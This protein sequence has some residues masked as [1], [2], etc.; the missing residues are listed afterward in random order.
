[1]ARVGWGPG[2]GARAVSADL[3]KPAGPPRQGGRIR[4]AGISSSTADTLD[5]ARGSLSTDYVRHN[6]LYSGLTQFDAQLR[7][8]PALAEAIETDDRAAW[9]I[10]L[11]K[12]VEFHDGSS[13]T[14][15][16]VVYSLM[17]HK[18]PALGSKVKTIAD[19]IAEV[20]A[21]GP[22]EVQIRLTGPNADFPLILAT[23]H[24]GIIKDGTTD[25]RTAN[26]CGPYRLKAFT[27]GVRTLVARNP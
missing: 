14:A 23:S 7:P 2:S 3:A 4:V 24:F 6:M 12:G 26:G 13:L 5:P 9:T 10:R 19:Q 20:R 21:V 18:E 25:F 27:P 17:R 16:D 15:N 11:K 1:G 8:Q 22:L